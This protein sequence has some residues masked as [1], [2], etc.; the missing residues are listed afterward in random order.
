MAAEIK[1]GGILNGE[2]GLTGIGLMR[3]GLSIY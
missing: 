3:R 2:N 1:V